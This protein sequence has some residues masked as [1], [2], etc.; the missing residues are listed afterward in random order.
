MAKKQPTKQ[1]KCETCLITVK[2]P[3][4]LAKHCLETGHQA[5]Q[6]CQQCMKWFASKESL[7]Q[8]TA[9]K[10]REPRGVRHSINPPSVPDAGANTL[11]P[12]T[13]GSYAFR[14]R[15]YKNLCPQDMNVVYNLLLVACHSQDRLRKEGY[16][17]PDDLNKGRHNGEGQVMT[18]KQ[19]LPTPVCDSLSPK[20]KAVVL[21]CEM[22]GVEGGRSEV[23]SICAID[24]FTGEILIN[25]LV[26][27]REQI[28]DWRSHIHGIRPPIMS[29]AVARRQVL[30]GWATARGELWKHVNENTVLV[31][32]SPHFDLKALRVVHTKIVDTAIVTTEAA[33]GGGRSTGRRWGLEML[34]RELL[35]L[36]I[37]QGSGVHNGLEDTMA[38][39]ELA[40]WCLCYPAELQQWGEKARTSFYS[41]RARTRKRRPRRAAKPPRRRANHD[42]EEYYSSDE[43]ILRWEDVVDWEIWPKSPPDSD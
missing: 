34:C 32:Q 25:S 24:F 33:F 9:A 11:S 19:C 38:T 21:D 20:R 36:R 17:L 3:S 39:R 10:H 29:I 30:D 15:T 12:P 42:G 13:L 16:I 7:A 4:D 8:H 18:L 26:K 14:D 2:I 28:I 41:E 27:P 40:L 1:R 22:A 35:H 5:D 37:R 23:V 6:C 31:G 43:D